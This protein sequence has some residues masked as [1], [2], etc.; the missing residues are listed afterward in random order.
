MDRRAFLGV[1][2]AAA[3]WPLAAGAETKP[4]AW[5][6]LPTEPYRG[7]QDDVV[8]LDRQTG[9]YGNG[10]GR[11]FRTSDGG[12]TWTRLLDRPGTF[13]RALGF[14]D[15]KL[16]F[17]GN[18]G[19][20]YFP[21]VTDPVPLYRTRDGGE[22]WEPVLIMGPAVTGICAINVIREP[23]I[24]AGV[25][26]HRVTIRAGGRVGGPALMATSRDG[27]ET[28]TSEDL[29]AHT[30]MILD[31]LFVSGRV[32]FIAG[33]TS[34]DVQASTALIL[35]TDD[36]GKSWTRVY[37][38]GRPWELTWKV[39][40]PSEAVGYVTVQSYN[41]DPA[42]SRRYVAKTTDG[43]RTWTELPLIDNAA[44]RAFGIG[45]VDENR[46]WVGAA[47]G[48][49]ETRDGGRTWAPVEMG[50]AVNKIRVVRDEGRTSLFAIGTA[51]H[52]LDL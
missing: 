22:Q 10:L 20:G 14:V 16:G 8:F 39:A 27:G 52:R 18:I 35:R 48:G 7:K 2:G 19:P 24:N 17:M 4:P 51:L 23:F 21:N 12:Q 15:E 38:G 34:T 1:S 30:A 28:W 11:L 46:G 32:G 31:I 25:L 6:R 47:P 5:V 26:D 45:F 29:S 43:G 41:P 13:V 37:E 40:F 9:W 49:F 3:L 42:A 36:G 33:A 50:A 44:V